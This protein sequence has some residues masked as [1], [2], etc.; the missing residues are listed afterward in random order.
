MAM[1]HDWF[2]C[3]GDGHA[4]VP[5][6]DLLSG[7][8]DPTR[9][10]LL[11]GT[12]IAIASW[13]GQNSALAQVAVNPKPSSDKVLVVLF[14]RGGAD[15]LSIVVPY[16]EDNYYRGRPNLKV[17][18]PR[19]K[20]ASEASRAIDLDGFFG[21]NPLLRPLLPFYERGEL[22][23]LHAVGSN[24]PTRSHFQAMAAMEKGL[25]AEGAGPSTGWVAR[26]LTETHA[27]SSS[28][29]RAVAFGEVLPDSLRGAPRAIVLQRLEEFRLA[30][31][32]S[33]RA[34]AERALAKLYGTG[35]DEISQAGRDTLATI[36]ALNRLDAKTYKPSGGAIYPV[37]DLA[38][39]LKQVALLVKAG[40]GLEVACLDKGGW[41]THVTQGV[42]IA[43]GQNLGPVGGL[44]GLIDDLGKSL[45]AFATDL[46]PDLQ[47]VTL[48][49]MTE[50]GRRVI[51][52]NALGTDHGRAST[53]FVLGG[54]VKGGRV[55]SNWPGLAT[56]KLDS[57]GDLRVGVDYRDLLTAVLR[58]HSGKAPEG[59]FPDFTPSDLKLWTS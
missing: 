51:E 16:G 18:S 31:N 10:G 58:Q 29:L 22:L 50:F 33:E 21:L 11:I 3:D 49:V 38:N 57:V 37:S 56:S 7:L 43:N 39:G 35:R 25:A 59:V 1:K 32:D 27:R 8:G 14:L 47:R 5:Q 9:R 24:D 52:N 34:S 6:P 15:G 12:S 19:D 2:S 55:V 54:G 48:V 46:G 23:P 30:V 42:S 17:D 13:I 20:R 28:P 40:L 4:G 26:Y 53:A 36:D 41:D 45:A 44:P